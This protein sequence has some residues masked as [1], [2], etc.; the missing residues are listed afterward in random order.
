M[1]SHSRLILLLITTLSIS[2]STSTPMVSS[3]SNDTAAVFTLGPLPADELD[4]QVAA[5]EADGTLAR[6]TRRGNPDNKDCHSVTLY[7]KPDFRGM[8]FYGCYAAD[9]WHLLDSHWNK[10][11]KSVRMRQTASCWWFGVLGSCKTPMNMKPRQY[12]TWPGSDVHPMIAGSSGCFF[13]PSAEADWWEPVT[14]PP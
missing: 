4:A 9:E 11:M 1:I 5:L 6:L 10:A 3:N 7:D 2:F 13:C 14:T 12:F 8:A